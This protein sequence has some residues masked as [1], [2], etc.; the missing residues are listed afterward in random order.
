MHGY[1][2]TTNSYCASLPPSMVSVTTGEDENP[3]ASRQGSQSFRV[4]P[5]PTTGEFTVEAL[6][7]AGNMISQISIYNLSGAKM[8]TVDLKGERSHRCSLL[9]VP[10]GIYFIHVTTGEKTGVS[11][12]IKL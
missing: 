4:F 9:D 3:G 8:F 12:L 10:T 11:K 1:I 6:G 5:N 2:T 7:D